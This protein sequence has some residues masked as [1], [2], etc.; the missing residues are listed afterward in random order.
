[1]DLAIANLCRQ[2]EAD[3]LSLSIITTGDPNGDGFISDTER[4]VAANLVVCHKIL[5]TRIKYP[6]S[7]LISL[8]QQ[9][10]L[11]HMCFDAILTYILWDCVPIFERR[12]HHLMAVSILQ[13]FLFGQALCRFGG[14]DSNSGESFDT[15]DQLCVESLEN[16]KVKPYVQCLLPR[17]NRGKALERLLIDITHA[18][19]RI[20]KESQPKPKKKSRKKSCNDTDSVNEEKQPSP[21]QNLCKALLRYGETSGSIPFCSLRN[22]AHRLKA[23]LPE[24]EER[25]MLNIRLNSGSDWSPKTDCAVAN[26]IVSS[27]SKNDITAAGKRCAFVGWE[28]HDGQGETMEA[29]RSLN[30]EELAMEE[31]HCGRLPCDTEEEEE[32]KGQWVGWHNEGGHVRALFRILCLPHLLECCSQDKRGLDEQTTTFLTKYQSSPHDLHVGYFK[33]DDHHSG[34]PIRGFYERRRPAIESFLSTLTQMDECSISDLIYEAVKRRWE[35]HV[36][37]RS[38]LKDPR[39]LRDVTEFK[40]LTLIA[41]A[42]GPIALAHIFRTLC[43]DYRHWSG[44]LPDLFLV[45]ARYASATGPDSFVDLAD[46]IG[47]GFSHGQIEEEN[48]QRHINMLVDRDDEFLGCSKNADGSSS[49]QK[50]SSRKKQGAARVELPSFPD[51]LE[52]RHMERNILSESMFVEVKSAND[53]LSERQED[54]LSILES[55]SNARVCKFSNSK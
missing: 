42:L 38:R 6:S 11:R 26:A 53:R 21:I 15:S 13:T 14:S 52:F 33:I 5:Q 45:R 9:P 18:E 37:D 40:T 16:L 39:L 32:V 41:G 27:D 50:F 36:D 22:L 47:E 30:V 34:S 43:F 20:K 31:Y 4:M 28:L 54:W 48:I 12:G 1:M 19:R 55:C 10:W 17:R 25:S 29:K 8:V 3:I 49:Q 23:P 7:M 51:K 24:T 44:G 46:W 35:R 2:I